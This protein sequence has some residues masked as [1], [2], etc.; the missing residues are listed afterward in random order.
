VFFER[1]ADKGL[2]VLIFEDLQWADAGLIDFVESILEWS[3]GCSL[4]I[5]TLARPELMDRR[6]S[7]GAGCVTSRH[8]T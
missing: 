7:W 6:P 2:T 5:V 4:L 8:F 3:K 1:I